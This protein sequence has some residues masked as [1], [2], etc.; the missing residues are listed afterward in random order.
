MLTLQQRPPIKVQAAL[1]PDRE[2][3]PEPTE[4]ESSQSCMVNLDSPVAK[5]PVGRN[6]V[7]MTRNNLA[8][9]QIKLPYTTMQQHWST[10]KV[11]G[12]EGSV[13][14]PE[15][16]LALKVAV[17]KQVI[18]KNILKC[19]ELEGKEGLILYILTGK[20]VLCALFGG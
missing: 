5:L 16:T 4:A 7:T 15:S 19:M 18:Y 6:L 9:M 14:C 10:I 8:V 17:L 20:Q 13:Q 3:T 1:L 2:K 11:D 12:K